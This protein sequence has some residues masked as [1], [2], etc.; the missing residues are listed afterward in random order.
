MNVEEQLLLLQKS[1]EDLKLISLKNQLNIISGKGIT[2]NDAK[3]FLIMA[4]LK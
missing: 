3:F 1:I 4:Q 2:W